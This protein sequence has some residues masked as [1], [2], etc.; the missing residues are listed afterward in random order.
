[1]DGLKGLLKRLR[2]LLF[3]R[4]ADDELKDELRFHVELEAERHVRE[5]VAPDEARR[6]ALASLGGVTR[7]VEEHREV[8][9][10]RWLTEGL[11]DARHALRGLAR[12]P[13]LGGAAIVTLAL[14]LGANT[15]IFSTVSAVVLRD[16][17]FPHP[18]RLV[19]LSEDNPEKHWVRQ[20][21]AP[22]NY[23]D[24]KERVRA[25]QDVAAYQPGGGS[26][27]GGVGETRQIRTRAI[28]GNYFSV[29]GVRPA[30]GRD[31]TDAETWQQGTGVMLISDQLWRDAF[32]ADRGV[33]G[34][35]VR[36][37]GKP[38]QIV[39]VMPA[40]FRFAAD[41]FDAWPA[42]AWNPQNRAQVFFRRAHFVRVIARLKPGVTPAVA[43]A[44]F[45]GV[46]R[47]LQSEYPTTNRVMGA[48]LVPLQDFLIDDV[49]LPLLMLQAAGLLLLL[50]AAANVANLL[51]ARAI[52]REREFSL[53]LTLG[54]GRGRLIR[55]TIAES[56]VL[57]ALGGGLGFAM[58]WWGSQALIALQPKGL[59][60]VDRIAVDWRVALG[61]FAITS[62]TGLLFGLAPALWSSRRDPA[63]VLKEG[64]RGTSG[65][66][67]RWGDALIV[68][69][70]AVALVLATGAGLLVKSFY[71]LT[72][73]DSGVSA[74]GVV[75]VSVNLPAPY[76]TSNALSHLFFQQTMERLHAEAD[77]AGAELC[78][79][80]PFSGVGYTSDYAIA[81]RGRED[82]G[83]EI[84]HDYVSPGYFRLLGIRLVAGRTFT[85][86]DDSGAAHVVII[87]EALA[88]RSFAG[89]DPIG[90]RMT[91][92]KYPDSTS[93][94]RTIVGVVADVRQK[95]LSQNAQVEMYDSF[96]QQENSFQTLLI[97][98]RGDPAAA[99][100]T[101]RR[102]LAEQNSSVVPAFVV[103]LERLQQQSIARQRFVMTLLLALA[104]TGCILALIGVYSVMAQMARRRT[105]EMGIR[106]ALGA[107]ASAV[108]WLMVRHGLTVIGFAIA[109]GL[110]GALLGAR[111][112]R[113]LLFEIGPSDP[114]TLGAVVLLLLGTALLASWIPAL[115]ASRTQPATTLREE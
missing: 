63:D 100:R 109:L 59:L 91:D 95:G 11:A 23:L 32:G 78:I 111:V 39:G 34:K 36:L 104:A 49:R 64:G 92:D 46:V 97:R 107:Q 105:R 1:M 29:L 37:D 52:G 98:P 48:D 93:N 40:S 77:I 114:S 79:V 80:P 44:E 4:R 99:I 61:M 76:D 101:T 33:I 66:M 6:R 45:Q 74:P 14:G 69:E 35:I 87:N 31:L 13:L 25:F 103:S 41:S 10:G 38:V 54:A 27:L 75:A 102:I 18:E 9:S 113:S 53:R 68:G 71:R 108:Q 84:A 112:I 5:G 55:Q 12:N 16:L 67:R 81:G 26:T 88:R 56:L 58:G 70:V 106:I 21:A 43:D 42:V 17:P 50:I 30:L 83:T 60:P 115:R 96:G 85:S 47:R 24:W 20:T 72:H 8:R 15:A 7:A 2:A 90:Q 62:V 86:A 22:A 57:A 73:V 94:W 3:A 28:T 89:Q 110:S 51:L 65:R 82:Y 19:M